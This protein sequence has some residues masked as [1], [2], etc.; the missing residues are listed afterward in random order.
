MATFTPPTYTTAY[1]P[2]TVGH[3]AD[4]S[5]FRWYDGITREYVVIITSS[6]P[7]TYPGVVSP[8][9]SDLAGADTGS[10]ENG[11][12]IFRGGRAY[13]IT[14]AENTALTNAGY[15]DELS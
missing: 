2:E 11:L 14:S 9:V 6:T 13:T 7:S 12:A 10:G 3:D 5:L 1:L 15:T 4:L 8:S